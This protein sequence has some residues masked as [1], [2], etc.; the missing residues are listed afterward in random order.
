MNILITLNSGY[1]KPLCV[2]LRSLLYS[3]PNTFFN[4]YCINKS[5]SRQDY[6]FV[7]KAL[8]SDRYTIQDIKIDDSMLLDAPITDRYPPEMYYRI[9]AS[10]YLPETV[11]RILYLDPDLVVLKPL[12]ELYNMDMGDNFFAAA[13]HVGKR[14]QKMNEL[15]LQMETKGPYINSGVM[16][17]N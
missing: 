6:D 13:S 14:L 5:L 3:N 15:R 12:D 7:D 16:L 4:I 10:K 11:D 1:I 8:N 17:M 9:F 2:M